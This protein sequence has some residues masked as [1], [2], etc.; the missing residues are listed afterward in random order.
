MNKQLRILIL[1]DNVVDAELMERELHRADIEF[2]SRR[3]DTKEDFQRELADFTPDL[4]LADY[5]LPSFDGCSAMKIVKEMC[6]DVPFIFV[7]G[8]I[9]EDFAIETLKSGATDYVLKDRLMRL[10][11]AVHRALRE[12]KERI[13]HRQ[14]EEELKIKARLLDDAT[15]SVFVHD[16]EGNFIYLNEGAYKSRGFGKEEM[17]SMNLHSI[18]SPEYA[19]LIKPRIENLIKLGEV[20]YESAH[21]RKDGSII[22]VET[23]AR[24]IESDNKKLVLS[25]VRD[26][27]ER[28]RTEKL[29][30]ER[31]RIELYGF[32]VSA[33]PLFASG[34][35]SHVKNTLISTF[36]E[37][38]ENNIRKRFEEE[39]EFQG[40]GKKGV[41]ESGEM[42]D[43]FIS[44]ISGL[45]S[46][47]GIKTRLT[48]SGDIR[49]LEFLNCSWL[50][51]AQCNPIFCLI[52][53]AM[54]IRSFS[55]TE[56]EG[57]AF[58][59]SSIA[60]GSK[61]CKFEFHL[62]QDLQTRENVQ[63][64]VFQ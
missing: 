48:S 18:V 5:T 12:F 33:L 42:L 25:I 11:P 47:F 14:D 23:H 36:T 21:L 51:E 60:G 19:N 62:T 61:I 46:N 7:S 22:P 9:G 45:F 43:A 20:T 32:I 34:V 30:R 58:Q 40:Y 41:E 24:I 29:L 63:L 1:E 55:W 59:T 38:F 28:K 15:D 6:L 10:A 64:E 17:M 26:V 44:W 4:I 53:R 56:L 35:S 52:C 54:V 50:D 16:T 39:M 3:V 57:A 8:T 37:R 27:T 49:Q 2:K 31:A 13:K